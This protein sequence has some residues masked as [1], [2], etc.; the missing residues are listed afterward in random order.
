MNLSPMVAEWAAAYEQENGHKPEKL[1]LEIAEHIMKVGGMLTKQ[2]QEDA[3][4]SKPPRPAE[5]F[6]ALVEKVFRMGED[7]ET[8]QIVAEVWQ[9]DYMKGY[10]KG[11]AV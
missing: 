5:T 1:V 10:R 6:P 2:G 4:K 9:L 8:V 7:S 3:Q 11:G